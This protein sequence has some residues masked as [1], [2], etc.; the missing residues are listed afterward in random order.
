MVGVVKK[1]RTGRGFKLPGTEV[2][3]VI[4]PFQLKKTRR[5]GIITEKGVYEN[6]RGGGSEEKIQKP[7]KGE[8]SD[9]FDTFKKKAA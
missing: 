8:R 7:Q 5:G 4:G 1:K 2:M 9:G 3:K 6:L